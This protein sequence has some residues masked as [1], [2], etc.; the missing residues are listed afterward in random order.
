[1]LADSS[2]F[3]VC[4]MVLATFNVSK[5]TENGVVLEPDAGHT[6]GNIRRE[7][8]QLWNDGST[9]FMIRLLQSSDTI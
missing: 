5:Y 1:M 8:F 4:V 7:S 6:A 9:K 3:I 2:I